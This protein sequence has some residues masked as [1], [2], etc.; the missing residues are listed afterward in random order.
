[1]K[2]TYKQKQ[3]EKAQK[4]SDIFKKNSMIELG[5]IQDCDIIFGDH[6]YAYYDG[7]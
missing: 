3:E 1:M 7:E 2:K 6:D 5:L 4:L